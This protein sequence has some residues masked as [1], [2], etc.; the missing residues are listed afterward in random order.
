MASYLFLGIERSRKKCCGVERRLRPEDAIGSPLRG[1]YSCQ[2][3]LPNYA[4]VRSP[5][6]TGRRKWV[7]V[8]PVCIVRLAAGLPL[9]S[10]AV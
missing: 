3:F 1:Y 6:R 5:N 4:Y 10:E 2:I 9:L 7:P 8:K